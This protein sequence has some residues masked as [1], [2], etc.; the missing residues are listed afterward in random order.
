MAG[1]AFG[2]IFRVNTWGESHGTAIGAVI[3]GCPAGLALSEDDIQKYLDRRKPGINIFSTQRKESDTVHILSGVFE[4]KTTG[5]PISL[6][7]QNA[8][9]HSKD[10]S[11]IA[12]IYRPGHADLSFD[13][14]YGFRDYRG[15]GR[16]S[17]RETAARVCGGA[18]ALKVLE[19]LGISVDAYT[20]AIGSVTA[21][22]SVIRKE[23]IL[24]S[25]IFM[26]DL[27]KSKEAEA[28]IEE[29]R[30]NQDSIGGKVDCV[31]SGLPAGLGEPVFDKLDALLAHAVMSIGAVKGVQ[32]GDG[33]D[34]S[35][36]YGSENNDDFIDL[37]QG[38][39]SE[40]H[41]DRPDH[42]RSE[43]DD[44]DFSFFNPDGTLKSYIKK[45]NHAGGILGGMSDSDPVLITAA[46][47]PTPSISQ[48]Q[49]T[50]DREGQPTKISIHGRHDPVIVPRAVVVV[51]SMAA[52]TVLDLLMRN[53][54][55]RMDSI[56]KLYL[57]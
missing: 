39:K 24:K 45:T 50:V 29:A 11:D 49:D 21:D 52:M 17:G 27:L 36:H 22:R 3:D 48:V 14:K 7:I 2:N 51:Q 23:N 9:Q 54:S 46:F 55:A 8:D 33:F 56:K 6:L 34:A 13:S 18:V 25:P 42:D 30:K 47:K 31:I 20:Y 35:L 12:D 19:E 44:R 57:E 37:P 40:G 53:M 28:L 5:T 38:M 15:G 16:S 43:K 26:P 41:R 4:G 10:Y 1:S 32:I